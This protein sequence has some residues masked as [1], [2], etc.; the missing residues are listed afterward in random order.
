MQS[1][2]SLV[3]L[4]KFFFSILTVS[5]LGATSYP[6]ANTVAH[7]VATFQTQAAS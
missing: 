5:Q 3:A 4:A 7:D 1:T 6:I 2:A